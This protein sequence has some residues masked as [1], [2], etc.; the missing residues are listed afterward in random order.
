MFYLLQQRMFA[1]FSMLLWMFAAFMLVLGG[2]ISCYGLIVSQAPNVKDK[3]DAIIPWQGAI[4]AIL[5][6][7]WLWDLVMI[8]SLIALFKA[9]VFWWCMQLLLTLSKFVLWF[10]LGY[11][12]VTK[13]MTS[14]AQMD[15]AKIK[16]MYDM[17]IIVQVPFGILAILLGLFVMVLMVL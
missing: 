9:S 3:L 11:G 14:K 6:L 7:L 16:S 4:W 2:L 17:L 5:L 10:T 8:G 13:F 15:P 12:V 1:K